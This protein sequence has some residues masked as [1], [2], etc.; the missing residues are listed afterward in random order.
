MDTPDALVRLISAFRSLPTV[1]TKTATRFAYKII[2]M[3]DEDVQNFVE[4]IQDAKQKIKFCV[5]CGNYSEVEVCKRCEKADKSIICVVKDPKD[6]NAFERTG[7]FDGV[8]HVLHGTLDFTKGIGVSEI[9]IKELMSRL[10][11]VKEVIIATNS[12]VSGELTASHLANL[13]KPLGIKVTRL[14]SGLPMGSEI[15]YADEVTLSQ[16]LSNRKEL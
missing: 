7:A 12:D 14:A 2:D 6:I 13:I 4:A 5:E 10:V 9:R 11:G 1:G 8:Y 15:E 16:A 3:S